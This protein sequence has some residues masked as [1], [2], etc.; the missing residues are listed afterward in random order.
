MKI[1]SID[2]GAFF[3]LYQYFGADTKDWYIN[4]ILCI[5]SRVSL[6]LTA[7]F[8]VRMELLNGQ[9]E[10]APVNVILATVAIGV[11]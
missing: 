6:A 10:L 4:H 8:Y 7:V 11:N 9:L 1:V 3:L 2:L 5:N